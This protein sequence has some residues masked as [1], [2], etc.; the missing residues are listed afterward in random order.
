MSDSA[1]AAP[2]AKPK[3]GALNLLV[4]YGPIAVFFLVYRTYAPKDHASLSE[5]AAVIRAT[6]S[7]MVAALIALAVSKWKL[8]KVSPMLWLSTALIVVFGGLTIV[9]QDRVWIQI[10]PTVIYLLFG[11]ALLAGYWRGVPLL[12]TLLQAAFEGLDEAGW[13]KL[14]RNWG[15]FFLVLA[16]INEV[17][18]HTLQFGDWIAAKLW[19]F[20]PLTFLFTFTQVPMLLRHGLAQDAEKDVLTDPPHE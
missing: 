17:L 3:S 8:G 15:W 12:R 4:D 13:M 7:F 9:F 10:K 18:R 20:L 16:A 1:N 2:P 14:S 6:G 5:V 11:I 19:L